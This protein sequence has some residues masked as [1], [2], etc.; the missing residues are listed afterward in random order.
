MLDISRYDPHH[1]HGSLGMNSE[2]VS[3]GPKLGFA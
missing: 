1:T 2:A 3:Q